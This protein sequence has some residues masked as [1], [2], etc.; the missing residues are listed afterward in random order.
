V[1]DTTTKRRIDTARDILVGKVPDPK[2]QVE[3][4]TIALIYKF[5]DDMDTESEELGGKRKFFTGDYARYGWAKLMDR[6][7]G[8]HEMLGLYG[9]GIAKIP[10]NPGIP[11]SP[12]SSFSSDNPKTS[13]RAEP[14]EVPRASIFSSAGKCKPAQTSAAMSVGRNK[15]AMT[16]WIVF[17]AESLA[18]E[19]TRAVCCANM[20]SDGRECFGR[21][22]D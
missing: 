1:L 12:H 11:N 4:I 3:Q 2:S 19:G 9:E 18:L 8:G 6:S 20:Q 14:V 10:E 22:V 7:L 13:A 15:S 21:L 16:R 17:M 5:M